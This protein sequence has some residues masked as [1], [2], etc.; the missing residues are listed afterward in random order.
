MLALVRLTVGL[1]FLSLAA[2]SIPLICRAGEDSDVRPKPRTE[3][4]LIRDVTAYE[5][6]VQDI[7]DVLNGPM[8]F[9]H[10]VERLS[11]TLSAIANAHKVNIVVDEGGMKKE[12]PSEE[13]LAAIE[14]RGRTVGEALTVLLDAYDLDYYVDDLCIQITS[15]EKVQ[16]RLEI[17][18]YDV[19][20]LLIRGITVGDVAR[21]L[22]V[23]L[24]AGENPRPIVLGDC[25]ILSLTRKD[26]ARVLEFLRKSTPGSIRAGLLPLAPVKPVKPPRSKE[27]TARDGEGRGT[28]ET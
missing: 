12:L 3:G 4:E 18:A 25:V 26:H 27:V 28:R 19:K 20:P 11:K 14:L 13:R 21:V 22:P 1:V 6:Q 8:A 10:R 16:K 9:D 2:V 15:A 7:R 17:R 24:H 5:Q 23:S